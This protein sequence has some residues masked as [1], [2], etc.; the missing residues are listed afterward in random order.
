MRRTRHDACP[1]GLILKSNR[2]GSLPSLANASGKGRETSVGNDRSTEM[3]GTEC[4]WLADRKSLSDSTVHMLRECWFLA[5]SLVPAGRVLRRRLNNRGGARILLL[6]GLFATDAAMRPLRIA[7]RYAGYRPYRWGLG[8]NLGASADLFDRLD[9]RLDQLQRR[10]DRPVILLGWSFGGLMARE[11]A[12]VAPHRV[13]A[14]I[15]L[16]SPFSGDLS[17]TMLARVY[18][19]IAGHRVDAPPIECTLSEKPPVPTVAIWSRCDGVIP[20]SAARGAVGEADHRIEVSCAHLA[21]PSDRGALAA[22]MEA[23]ARCCPE[24]VMPLS[25]H[26]PT[27]AGGDL[28]QG[29]AT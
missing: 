28:V 3:T 8:R 10:D 21:F 11:Y 27:F 20:A 16:G 15:T 7:L 18:E 13:R 1:Y 2:D 26:R 14:V 19:W 17:A 22:V 29:F 5:R 25:A 12:K 6:P 4:D 23:I 24:E 9:R